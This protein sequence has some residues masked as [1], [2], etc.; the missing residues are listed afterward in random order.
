VSHAGPSGIR[1]GAT[2]CL[3][4]WAVSLLLP[5]VHVSG[6]PTLTGAGMLEQGWQA[7]DSGVPSWYANP[8]FLLACVAAF[9]GRPRIAG[10]LM[11]VALTL[12]L[13]SFWAGAIARS[14]GTNVPTLIWQ[15]GF[16][17]WLAAQIGLFV[18]CWWAAVARYRVAT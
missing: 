11:G 6:G 15:A 12:A 16:Y 7:L 17:C 5:A 18:W 10:V 8:V 13:T 3:V 4:L 1:V 2:V 14:N 9:L